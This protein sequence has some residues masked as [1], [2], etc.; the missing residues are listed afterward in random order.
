MPDI[1]TPQN[2][3]NPLWSGLLSGIKSPLGQGL[4]SAA[5]IGLAGAKRGQPW[6]NFGKALQ[7]GLLGYS[8]AVD[9]QSRDQVRS[10]QLDQ[11]K[12]QKELAELGN[13]FYRTPEQNALGMG[14]TQGSAVQGGFD[15][16]GNYVPTSSPK[17]PTV[18]NANLIASSRPS[19]DTEGYLD[20]RMRLDPAGTIALRS[21]MAKETP[22]NKVDPSNFTP[23]SLGT[24]SRTR[25]YADLVPRNKLENTNGVWV[26]PY[27]G[28]T[29]RV[30]PQD[31]N[32][33]FGYGADGKVTPNDA[34][35][36]Y[37]L[38]RTRA[39]APSVTVK[40]E[41][42]T[43]ESIAGQI[44]PMVKDSYTAAQGAVQTATAADQVLRSIQ[45]G[46]L[47]T[48]PLAGQRIKGLQIAEAMGIG[49]RDATERLN[50][51]RSAI[52]GLAQMTLQGRKQMSGQ[53]AVTES[54]SKLAERAM[55]GDIEMTATELRTLASAAK[56][57]AQ[58]TYNQ[59]QTQLKNMR[60]RQDLAGMADF[61]TTAP[62]PSNSGPIGD[63]NFEDLK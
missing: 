61:Y 49:G 63:I 25:N 31:P 51:T 36:R 26:D 48:G 8:D 6:N 16:Q 39:G 45:A 43:G 9:Q 41:V 7:G 58:W 29:V 5:A 44:G 4:L 19:F 47:V 28:Q 57:A 23:E 60:G 37:E 14:A 27:S 35:Q 34:F 13:Q 46:N 1:T 59:H 10:F 55:S 52:Q 11:L 15:G 17:G 50:N 62:F 38:S 33:P 30:G 53:G 42:K 3:D 21:S 18:A 24:F 12:R 20:A 2:E 54:E 56:R 40:N 22:F 32:K